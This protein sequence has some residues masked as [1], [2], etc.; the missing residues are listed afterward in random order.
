MLIFLLIFSFVI[1]K[2]MH[3]IL[4]YIPVRYKI[5]I[6]ATFSMFLTY[7]ASFRI[8]GNMIFRSQ[9]DA[10]IKAYESVTHMQADQKLVSNI[11]ETI[12]NHMYDTF[13][14]QRIGDSFLSAVPSFIL[15]GFMAHRV[16]KKSKA[17]VLFS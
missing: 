8:A 4:K 2:L 1:F 11:A 16:Y 9:L 15:V 5:E 10:A 13:L 7:I 14:L 17:N 12:S 6:A 3:F